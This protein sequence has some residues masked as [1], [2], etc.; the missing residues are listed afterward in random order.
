MIKLSAFADE[1]TDDFIG[2]VKF[3]SEQKINYIELRFVNQKNTM[4]LNKDELKDVQKI[5]KDYGIKVSAIG[6]PIGKITL[7]KP[8][9]AHLDKLKHA[10]ELSQFF[11]TRLIRVFSY[12]APKGKNIVDYRDEVMRRMAAKLEII[13]DADVIMVHENEVY[14]YGETAQRCADLA[15]TLNSPKLRLVYD[16]ANFVWS[17]RTKENIK[18]CWPLM[19]PYVSHIH[20]KDWKVGADLGAMPGT[21]DAEIKELLVELKKMSY[22]GF[23]T[24]EPHLKKGG[25]FGGSTGP[26]L[27]AQA[28]AAVRNLCA[29]IK[30]ICK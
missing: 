4:E 16:P 26:E 21:G 23:M 30:L 24:M 3:L 27:F 28:I 11:E 6:S 22:E 8:F 1:V 5:L 17:Q 9:A 10:V 25:Q 29:D 12:Y 2:Q 18:I 19:K 14:I 13:R 7:D 20:I 15:K